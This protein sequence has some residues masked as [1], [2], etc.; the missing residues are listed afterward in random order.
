VNTPADAYL[1]ND[2]EKT[3]KLFLFA[4]TVSTVCAG[5]TTIRLWTFRLRHF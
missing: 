1:Q 4:E 5:S 3:L 2:G